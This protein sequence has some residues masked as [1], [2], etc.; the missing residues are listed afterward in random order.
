[1]KSLLCRLMWVGVLLGGA[2]P[3]RADPTPQLPLLDTTTV[4]GQAWSLAEHRGQWVVI[5]FWATW[6]GPCIKEMPEL[7]A[8]DQAR[9][10]VSVIGLAFEEIEPADMQAFLQR[11]PVSY[12]I[13][14]VDVYAPPADFPAP[15]GLP[16]TWLIGPDGQIADK[17]LGPVTRLD[18]EQAIS[19]AGAAAVH[20]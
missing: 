8:L 17:F 2:S 9:A 18:L 16:M 10:D 20:P 4:Q 7:D 5:N 1:M 15:K 13:A 12:P 6:C 3:L 11:R 19:R 14:V